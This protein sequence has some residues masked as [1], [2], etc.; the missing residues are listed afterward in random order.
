MPPPFT[1]ISRLPP[2]RRFGAARLTPYVRPARHFYSVSPFH[3]VFQNTSSRHI[4]K[5]KNGV[6]ALPH[7]SISAPVMFKELSTSSSVP[8]PTLGQ[9]LRMSSFGFVSMVSHAHTIAPE[10]FHAAC[11]SG[12]LVMAGLTHRS[13]RTSPLV[14]SASSVH[15]D[16]SSPPVAPLR[17]RPVN[18]IR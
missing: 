7:S 3:T 15:S 14:A 2:S 13:T 1:W 9:Q 10:S 4:N 16:F 11:S 6:T 18:S 17:C 8:S 5:L 12:R